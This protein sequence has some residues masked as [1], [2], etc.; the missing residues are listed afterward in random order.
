MYSMY[1][2]VRISN[3]FLHEPFFRKERWVFKEFQLNVCM[4]KS[5]FER[6]PEKKCINWKLP[7]KMPPNKFSG[8]CKSKSDLPTSLASL[9]FWGM[10]L[11]KG[12]R[13]L[14]EIT[15]R[16]YRRWSNNFAVE[17]SYV[18]WYSRVLYLIISTSNMID[19]HNN[20]RI[21]NNIGWGCK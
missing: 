1:M 19:S 7:A 13:L 4:Y 17:A 9:N 21:H 2:R 5:A 18:L 12:V 16:S 10:Q 3:N 8:F 11:S 14:L 6:L 20:I 15:L